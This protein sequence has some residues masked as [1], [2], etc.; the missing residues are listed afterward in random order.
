V[1][2]KRVG[3]GDAS[4]VAPRE[5]I[6]IQK[7]ALPRAKKSTKGNYRFSR[8]G[9]MR[10]LSPQPEETVP[11]NKPGGRE[12]FYRGGGRGVGFHTVEQDGELVC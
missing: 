1:G 6:E 7:R 3:S 11:A 9:K 10:G 2:P 8:D 5:A 12:V 4:A